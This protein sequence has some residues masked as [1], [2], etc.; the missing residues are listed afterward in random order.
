MANEILSYLEMCMREGVNLQKG[1]NFGLGPDY[2][3]LLMSVRHNAP[4]DDRFD[5]DGQTLIYEGHDE[6]QRTGQPDA[7]QIDQ[8]EFTRN[9]ALTENGKF[10]QA[11]RDY[12]A[13]LRTPERVR[14]YEKLRGGIWAFSGLFHLV[15]YWLES[16]GRRHVFKFKLVITDDPDSPEPATLAIPDEPQRVIPTAVKLA[17]WKR[18]GGKCV[19]CGATD[20]LHFDHII[21]FSKGGTSLK[22]ENIQLLCARHNLSK[23][24][25]LE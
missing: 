7:K 21:P 6:P 4:Y 5:D 22:A 18:D 14:V 20:E 24:S 10:A 17:V 19:T 9:G 8:P 25:K 3:V 11:V 23:G 15:D 2:S 12:Q 16:D 1:M 13:G